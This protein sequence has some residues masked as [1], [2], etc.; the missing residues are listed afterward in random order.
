MSELL[1]NPGFWVFVAFVS[2]M[3]VL[4]Y[5]NMHKKMTGALDSRAQT[6]KSELDAARALR[7]EAEAVLADYKAKQAA[8]MKEAEDMLTRAK[9]E[10]DALRE[11]A[12]KELL[13][14]MDM[15]MKSA[16]DRIQQ[17]EQQAIQDVRDH[18]VDITIAAAKDM[19]ADHFATLSS[20]DMITGVIADLDRK[21]H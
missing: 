20:E 19:I 2:F 7:E 9:A 6:I 11:N 10:A 21:V 17:Q 13:A 4:L 18:V 12:E 14:S 15:R 5:L 16:M 8:H 3:G 1:Q